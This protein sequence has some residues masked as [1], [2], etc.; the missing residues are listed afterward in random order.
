MLCQDFAPM[1]KPAELRKLAA[2]LDVQYRQLPDG[3]F[4]HSSVI[5]LI[6]PQGRVLARTS[7]LGGE[8]DEEFVT[9]LRKALAATVVR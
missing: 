1:S 5:S 6:D 2:V 7:A 4:N 8:P 3:N 9:A